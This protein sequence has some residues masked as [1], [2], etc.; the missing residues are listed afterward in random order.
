MCV[1]IQVCCIS[2]LL[3][4]RKCCLSVALW[5]LLHVHVHVYN[6][7]VSILNRVRVGGW[8][9]FDGVHVQ[10]PIPL[11]VTIIKEESDG[12]QGE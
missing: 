11:R 4:V 9:A 10:I 5:L 7:K 2:I 8:Q 3:R 6:A 1:V 12:R